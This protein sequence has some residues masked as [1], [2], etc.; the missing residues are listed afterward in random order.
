M[1]T[2]HLYVAW[3]TYMALAQAKL[4]Y[5]PWMQAQESAVVQLKPP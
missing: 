5:P 2:P 1:H 4:P 3:S